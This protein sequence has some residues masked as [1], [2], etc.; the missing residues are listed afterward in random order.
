[1]VSF[2]SLNKSDWPSKEKKAIWE[3]YFFLLDY[4]L[5]VFSNTNIVT[6]VFGKHPLPLEVLFLPL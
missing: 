3:G 5:Q 6:I 1:M 2:L 4:V